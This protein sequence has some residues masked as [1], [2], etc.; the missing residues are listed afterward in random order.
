[1][2]IIAQRVLEAS[3]TVEG[4]VV[5]KIG[6]GLL[7]LVGFNKGDDKDIIEHMVSKT[8]NM[9]LWESE[10]K[11]WAASVKDID[12]EI[13]VVS[14]F[15]LYA[16]FKGN[17]PDFHNALVAND[18]K[19]MYDSYVAQ[20]RNKFGEHKVQTGIFQAMMV[21]SCANDGPVT[22]YYD[23]GQGKEEEEIK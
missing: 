5:G 8:I 12:G 17:K 10:G 18:A 1:M 11:S 15:T 7:I 9:R 16:K 19:A 22:I 4:K 20:L 2:R 6:K 13:L 3:V 14:Q 23:K 21:V